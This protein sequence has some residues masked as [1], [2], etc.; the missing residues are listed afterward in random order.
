MDDAGVAAQDAPV[1]MDYF[2]GPHG[3]RLQALDHVGVASRGDEAD[4]LAVGLA[5]HRQ[6]EAIGREPRL[7]FVMSPRGKRRISS[8]ALVVAN[9]K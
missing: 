7:G 2:A 1:E 4:I 5:R 6:A 9:M 8:C 3:V